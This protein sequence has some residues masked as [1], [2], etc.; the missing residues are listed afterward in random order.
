MQLKQAVVE[1]VEQ[2]L[3]ECYLEVHLQ[4]A[5]VAAQDLV[6][7]HLVYHLQQPQRQEQRQQ[8]NRRPRGEGESVMPLM[9]LLHLLEAAVPVVAA[10]VQMKCKW[11]KEATANRAVAAGSGANTHRAV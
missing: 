11:E 6:E 9:A 1:A 3:V 2:C 7:S 8:E 4:G 5:Q 10:V